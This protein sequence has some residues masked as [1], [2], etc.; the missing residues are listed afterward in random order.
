M[1]KDKEVFEILPII[2]GGSP[3]DPKNKVTL[4]RKS[5]IEAVRYWNAI[6]KKIK[7]ENQ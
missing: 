6:I 4:D 1:D 5:H 2:L 3:S 7:E